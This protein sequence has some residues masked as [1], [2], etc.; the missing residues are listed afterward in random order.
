[1]P[2]AKVVLIGGAQAILL[3]E[4]FHLPPGTEEVEI[5][6]AGDALV[7]MPLPLEEWPEAFWSAFDGMPEDFERPL[8]LR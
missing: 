5:R 7:L 2:C 8:R 6:R 3:P 1:M 4:H